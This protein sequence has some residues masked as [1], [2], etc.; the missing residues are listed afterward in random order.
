MEVIGFLGDMTMQMIAKGV[1]KWERSVLR[2]LA[3]R[4]E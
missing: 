4:L 3:L 1:Q 2:P